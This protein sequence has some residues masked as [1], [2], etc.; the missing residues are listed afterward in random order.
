M[1]VFAFNGAEYGLHDLAIATH[2]GDGSYGALVS[3]P[4]VTRLSLT[5]LSEVQSLQ[6]DVTPSAYH[7]QPT[8]A[9]LDIEHLT[10]ALDALT[11]L[12]GGAFS[13]AGA[14]ASRLDTL[15]LSDA[16]FPA[17]GMVARVRGDGDADLQCFIPLVRLT[18]HLGLTLHHADLATLSLSGTA[19]FDPAV[20]L[21]NGRPALVVWFKQ[22]T[23]TALA[24][25][26]TPW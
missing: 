3:V 15:G 22:G 21:S 14:D 13:S 23:G 9:R 10:L 26:P 11:T 17:W 5:V 12:T 7:V 24:L 6:G 2:Q 16:P 4:A 1:S 8:G 18:H 25:P 20:T 19:L